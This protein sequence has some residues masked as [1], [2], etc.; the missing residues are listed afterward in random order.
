[1]PAPL[2]QALTAPLL[3]PV[4]TTPAAISA[5]IGAATR[6][7]A[8]CALQ[9]GQS[10]LTGF[11]GSGWFAVIRFAF[12]FTLRHPGFAFCLSFCPLGYSCLFVMLT[13]FGAF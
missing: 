9:I 8:A 13:F 11:I 3:E 6:S 10:V 7:S 1:M 12:Y 2:G 4:A 5:L